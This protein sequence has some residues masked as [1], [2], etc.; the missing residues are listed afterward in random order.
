MVRLTAQ[1]MARVFRTLSE[2]KA[3]FGLRGTH[4]QRLTN[5]IWLKPR[6]LPSPKSDVTIKFLKEIAR[7]QR[8]LLASKR[9]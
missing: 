9:R 1:D 2:A 5:S 4:L 3:L 6:R 8:K 7:K